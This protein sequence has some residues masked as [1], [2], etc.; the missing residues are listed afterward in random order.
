[1]K[2]SVEKYNKKILLTVLGILI[3]I[4]PLTIDVYLPAFLQISQSFKVPASQVQLTLTFYFLGIVLGQI[5]YGPIIDRFGKKPPLIFGISLFIVTSFG[6][7]FAQNIEQIIILRFLQA[8][9]GC[10]SIVISRAIVRDIYSLQESAQAFSNLILVMGLA[11]IIAPF[12]GNIILQKYD[13]RVIFIF[14][15]IYGILCLFLAIFK[16]PETG[17]FNNDEK[18]S[19]AFKKYFGIL[20]DH[21][22]L[23]NALCGSTMMAC[24]MSYM[25]AS[26]FLYLEFFHTS[27]TFYSAMFSLNAV[28]FISCAQ[29]NGFLLKKI[30][31]DKILNKLIYI[32]L[33]SGCCLVLTVFFEQN[34]FLTTFII[35]IL[36][37][38]C[39]AVNPN[40]SALSLANQGKHTGSASALFGTIQFITATVFSLLINHFHDDTAKPICIIIGSCGI[41]CFAIKKIFGEKFIAKRNAKNNINQTIDVIN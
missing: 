15:A 27:T 18:I 1:M 23:I 41:L 16:V 17:G 8:I 21:N 34:L 22:F 9:G 6:C 29:I 26:P 5:F 24:L 14:L 10:A 4:G 38:A 7:S 32:P 28:G 13:W 20:H 40:T 2:S 36:I 11:P 12:I 25:T 31:V 30:K 33:I 37:S 3:A 39:G 35:F 19:H